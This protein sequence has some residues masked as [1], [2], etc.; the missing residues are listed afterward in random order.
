V[1]NLIIHPKDVSTDFLKPIYKSVENAVTLTGGVGSSKI[2]EYIQ[3]S[4]RVLMMGHGSPGGLFSIGR[5]YTGTYVIGDW[6]VDDLAQKE[7]NVFIW[8]NADKFVT[9]YRLKGFYSGM[10]VSEVSEANFCGLNGVDQDMVDESNET[11]AVLLGEYI[12]LKKHDIY[13]NIRDTYGELAKNNPVAMYN[14]KRLYVA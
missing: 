11:F 9:K 7:E 6:C 2:K 3:N 10:F 1:K 4:E 12:T 13:N 8:C 5:F 14:W